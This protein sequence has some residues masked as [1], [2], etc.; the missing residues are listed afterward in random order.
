MIWTIIILAVL[1]GLF[2]GIAVQQRVTIRDLRFENSA[3]L[4][5]MIRQ[6]E[7]TGNLRAW[8]AAHETSLTM[9]MGAVK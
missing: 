5:D 2:A 9:I 3:C 4:D 7:I 8:V 1:A 6:A